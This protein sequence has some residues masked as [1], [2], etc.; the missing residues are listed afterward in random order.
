MTVV[1]AFFLGL[2]A[3]FYGSI[4]GGSSFLS[5]PGLI[6]LGLPP[7]IAIATNKLADLG[8]FTLA[9]IKF[10]RAKKIVWKYI[11]TL[12]PLALLAGYLGARLLLEIDRN[13]V[14]QSLGIIM[15]C[16]IPLG[17]TKREFGTIAQEVSKGRTVIGHIVYLGVSIYGGSLQIG[18]GPLLLYVIIYFFGLTIL[19][20]NATSSFC[21]LF[22]TLSAL[23]T[24]IA[25][26]AIDWPIG[27]AMLVGSSI[28]GY[29][30]THIAV[31]KGDLWTKRF[32]AVVVTIMAIRLLFFT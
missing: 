13:V 9:S 29:A 1:L 6:F 28:G 21:W 4:A 3:S 2:C 12:A 18:S 14:Q 16:L 19:Q 32:F 30:G 17:F 31:L 27:M 11:F 24:F 5:L 10:I 25:E 22:I 23:A 8:R 7:E 26:G 20:A 15:L